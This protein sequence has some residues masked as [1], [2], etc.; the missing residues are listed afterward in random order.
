MAIAALDL[1][2]RRIGLAIADDDGLAV[3]PI[4]ALER[5]SIIRD[6][7]L[8]RIRLA[9]YEVSRVVVGLP[10]NMDGSA[11]PAALAA[12]AFAERLHESSGLPIDLFDERLTSFEAEARL[13]EMSLG[14]SHGIAGG[15]RNKIRNKSK[16]DRDKGMIDA[17]AASIIL[18]GWLI[19]RRSNQVP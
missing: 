6:L 12:Q 14:H 9:E 17:V 16:S 7:E 11:G 13:R 10:L 5:H 15:A 4:G 1:G 3:H 8:I 19:R 18:E 2:R